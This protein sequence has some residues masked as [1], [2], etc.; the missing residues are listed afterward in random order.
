MFYKFSLIDA[1]SDLI[2]GNSSELIGLTG[3]CIEK[4]DSE[5][6]HKIIL[7]NFR[8]N[9]EFKEYCKKNK[10]YINNLYLTILNNEGI[11]IGSY[12]L[13]LKE[14]QYY[15]RSE[16]SE[17][18]IELELIGELLQVAA[19]EDLAIW[20]MRRS[21]LTEKNVWTT[22]SKEQR[23]GWIEV[24]RLHYK[25]SH[26]S[27]DQQNGKYYIDTANVTNSSD[28]FCALG[29]AINGPGGYYGYDIKSLE[30]CLCGGFGA[31]PPFV[32]YLLNVNSKWKKDISFVQQLKEVFSV[33]NVALVCN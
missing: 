23:I 4:M 9:D 24:A 29:E 21:S 12:Y 6:F 13:I 16:F 17:C 18:R 19:E 14:P 32:I 25:T 31:A 2:I 28:F 3:N 10:T 1:E 33:R 15:F 8:F 7:K 11:P 22:L 26:N 30:D 27:Q 5:V 20:E